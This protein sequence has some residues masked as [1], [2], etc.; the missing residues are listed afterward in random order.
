M[1]DDIIGMLKNAVERGGRPEQVA[2]SLINSGYNASEVQQALT[3]VTGGTLSSLSMP[4]QQP[5]ILRP[6]SSEAAQQ[7]R[8]LPI[9]PVPPPQYPKSQYQ[10][11]SRPLPMIRQTPSEPGAGKLILLLFILLILIGGLIA[12]I[13]FKDK[14]IDLFG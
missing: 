8:Q 1:R 13:I 5:P 3:F 6:L 9:S 11:Y 12:T 4:A 10:Q 7:R 14:V 2:Q